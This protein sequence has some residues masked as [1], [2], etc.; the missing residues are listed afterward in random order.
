M[1]AAMTNVNNNTEK[2]LPPQVSKMGFSLGWA[3]LEWRSLGRSL[4]AELL[5]TL[6]LVIIGCGA[7]SNWKTDFDVTQVRWQMVGTLTLY[8]T[9]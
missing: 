9:F 4:L 1:T 6:L 5:G 3:E 2:P 7:A 8:L